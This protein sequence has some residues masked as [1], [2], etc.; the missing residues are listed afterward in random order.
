MGNGIKH[1]VK[2]NCFR[3][4]ISYVPILDRCGSVIITK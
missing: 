1:A 4:N 2:E 3:N